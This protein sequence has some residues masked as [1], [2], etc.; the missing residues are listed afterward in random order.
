MECQEG[1]LW[2]GQGMVD[3]MIGEQA[4]WR[5]GNKQDRTGGWE[6]LGQ[7]SGKDPLDS[8]MM[9]SLTV[10]LVVVLSSSIVLSSI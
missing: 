1:R 2:S 8:R 4:R 5:A 6:L 10:A 9:Y 3:G 7:S